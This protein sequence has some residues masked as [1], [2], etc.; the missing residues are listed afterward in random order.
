MP[1][2]SSTILLSGVLIKALL[3]VLFFVFWLYDRRATCFIW[4]CAAY[5]FGTL[6]AA[7]FLVRGFAGEMFGIGVGVGALI[8]TFGSVWQGARAFDGRRVL[9]L[10]FVGAPCLWLLVCLVPGFLCDLRGRRV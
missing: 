10:A 3:C 5:G 1:I 7:V 6:A 9:W 2:D 4:W 8:A